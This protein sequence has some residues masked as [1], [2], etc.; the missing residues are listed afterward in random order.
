RTQGLSITPEQLWREWKALEVDFRHTRLDPRDFSLLPPFKS[1]QQAWQECFQAVFQ[2]D[3]LKGDAAAAAAVCVREMARRQPYPD[4][5]EALPT[6]QRHW[7]TA[8][9]S[10][11]DDAYLLPLL[12]RSGVAFELVLT[13]QMVGT[14][15]PDPTAFR[16]TL[17]RLQ[18]EP[19]EAVYV[20]D[21]Q[22]EDV[23]GP[24]LAGLRS[25][26]V[27][28]TGAAPDPS[29]PLPDFQVRSLTELPHLLSTEPAFQ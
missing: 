15:K 17:A 25:V 23:L 9:L 7:R 24:S 22:W 18:V 13:S 29:L 8:L 28:R 3:G 14:Y 2:R 19:E 16:E 6:M 1:Y 21:T 11:A 4:A 5:Q 10:N 20:G 12:E 26:W 27:N